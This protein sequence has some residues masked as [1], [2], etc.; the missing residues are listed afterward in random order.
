[1]SSATA[2]TIGARKV[3]SARSR[4]TSARLVEAPGGRGV[5]EQGEAGGAQ[6]VVGAWSPEGGED[7]AED[8]D[9][10]VDGEVGVGPRQDVEDRGGVRVLGVDEHRAGLGARGEPVAEV[11]DQVAL[12]VDDHHAA[13]GVDVAEDEVGEQR[14]LAAARGAH[15]V[16]VVAGVGDGEGDRP[17]GAGL[18]VA[19]HLRA[20]ACRSAAASAAGRARAGGGATALAPARARPG[21]RLVGGQVGEGG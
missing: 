20:S 12:G 1:M 4:G 17:A 3:S 7:R 8:P 16:E 11:G 9:Q 10:V 13:A 18:G 5:A 15:D 2:A 6:H 19:E 21:T 14:R